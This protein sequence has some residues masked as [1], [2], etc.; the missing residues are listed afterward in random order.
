V[1]AARISVKAARVIVTGA[2]VMAADA[3]VIVTDARVTM[4]IA[5]LMKTTASVSVTGAVVARGGTSCS[6]EKKTASNSVWPTTTYALSQKIF[7]F[8][9]RKRAARDLS[10]LRDAEAGQ[11]RNTAWTHAEAALRK[12]IES[13]WQR[14]EKQKVRWSPARRS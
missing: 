6:F 3:R 7:S 11:P 4:T 9:W 1:K 2:R 10:I 5:F 13:K 8:A 14:R 12:E